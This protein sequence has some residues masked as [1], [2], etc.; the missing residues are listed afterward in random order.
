[1]LCRESL[2]DGGGKPNRPAASSSVGGRATLWDPML[3]MSQAEVD[4]RSHVVNDMNVYEALLAFA[5]SA[6][7]VQRYYQVDEMTMAIRRSGNMSKVRDF[8]SKLIRRGNYDPSD[9]VSF[10]LPYGDDVAAAYRFV[11]D[12]IAGLAGLSGDTDDRMAATVAAIG[13][14]ELTYR[15]MAVDSESRRAVVAFEAS[16]TWGLESLTRIPFGKYAGQSLIPDRTEGALANVE[17]HW[18]WTEVVDF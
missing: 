18:Y 6:G 8:M 9:T 5:V 4:A 17:Q 16:N 12:P 15:V 11:A 13:S 14:Y 10:G 1:M 7:S 2:A 3:S